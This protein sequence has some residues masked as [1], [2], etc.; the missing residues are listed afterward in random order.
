M[1][2]LWETLALPGGVLAHC[3]PLHNAPGIF[4]EPGISWPHVIAWCVLLSAAATCVVLIWRL[5]INGGKGGDD[6]PLQ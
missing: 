3:T 5:V 1:I 4:W 2:G 6:V